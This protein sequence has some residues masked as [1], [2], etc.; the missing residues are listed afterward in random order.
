MY[1]ALHNNWHLQVYRPFRDWSLV[2]NK[3]TMCFYISVASL[4]QS[5]VFFSLSIFARV[6]F[7]VWWMQCTRFQGFSF[8]SLQLLSSSDYQ[9]SHKDGVQE[10]SN[11]KEWIYH[12]PWYSDRNVTLLSAVVTVRL[13]SVTPRKTFAILFTRENTVFKIT[14]CSC[15]H[16]TND[17]SMIFKIVS[18]SFF[19]LRGVSVQ[20]W[21]FVS[22]LGERLTVLQ[23]IHFPS[24]VTFFVC[25][26]VW[27][28]VRDW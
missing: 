17:W 28:C 27:V 4:C 19:S 15:C 25:L 20:M 16:Q 6:K 10:L 1:S 7:H 13:I 22:F 24:M 23:P 12:L 26:C 2:S 18:V 3:K 5:V 9:S 8:N 14:F 21:A 11:W